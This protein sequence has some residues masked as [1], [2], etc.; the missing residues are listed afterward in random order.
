VL[1]PAVRIRPPYIDHTSV[2]VNVASL[3]REQLRRAKPG[4]RGEDDDRPVDGAEL[5]GDRLDLL[6][7]LERPFLL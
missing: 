3:E 2:A 1:H 4:R 5:R 7:G 6:P